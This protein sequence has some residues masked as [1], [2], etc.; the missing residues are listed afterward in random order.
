[1]P[2]R[3]VEEPWTLR[4]RVSNLRT[5][6]YNT[7]ISQH[8]K[9]GDVW[10]MKGSEGK[11]SVVELRVVWSR[12]SQS[13]EGSRHSARIIVQINADGKLHADF[14]E[15]GSSFDYS[16]SSTSIASLVM[17]VVV[18]GE[19]APDSTTPQKRDYGFWWL[20]P[21]PLRAPSE[22][23]WSSSLVIKTR[24]SFL[25]VSEYHTDSTVLSTDSL[26]DSWVLGS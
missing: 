22:M 3:L 10:I 5:E 17:A 11:D 13:S 15:S 4:M 24:D 18:N 26:H 8:R 2:R 21:F 6:N 7:E 12:A 19:D 25:V 1:M 20:V 14:E 23:C 16:T 9:A